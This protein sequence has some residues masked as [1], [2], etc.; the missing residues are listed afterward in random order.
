M[1][2]QFR[3]ALFT[4]AGFAVFGRA[5]KIHVVLQGLVVVFAQ[6]PKHRH[7]QF[8]FDDFTQLVHLFAVQVLEVQVVAQRAAGRFSAGL[9]QVG[10]AAGPGAS[11]HQAFHF[12]RLERFAGRAFGALE[13]FHQLAFGGQAV[14]GL[15]GVG[16]DG[17]L[18][19]LDN[20]IGQLLAFAS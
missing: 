20:H 7:R 2:F 17:A 6:A 11:A 13:A 15:Q 16:D 10:A 1:E 4:L 19:R 9:V 5:A 14:T 12:Q 3:Q 18:D 8:H